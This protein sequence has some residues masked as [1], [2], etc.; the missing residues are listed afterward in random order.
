MFCSF[1]GFIGYAP[2]IYRLLHQGDINDDDDDQLYYTK[3]F[4]DKTKRVSGRECVMECFL[5]TR[6][7]SIYITLINCFHTHHLNKCIA[8]LV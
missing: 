5:H 8:V 6:T 4:L 2:Y 1:A 7:V 3:I